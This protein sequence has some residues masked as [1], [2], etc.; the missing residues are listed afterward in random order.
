MCT[1]ALYVY[2]KVALSLNIYIYTC[3]FICLSLYTYICIYMLADLGRNLALSE[4]CTSSLQ[5][6]AWAS[7]L[8]CSVQ[9][10]FLGL[11]RHQHGVYEEYPSIMCINVRAA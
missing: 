4:L 2:I 10:L 1:Y 8:G 3:V 9:R 5:T 7:S 11:P 6:T